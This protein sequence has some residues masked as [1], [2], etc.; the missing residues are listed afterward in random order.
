[1]AYFLCPQESMFVLAKALHTMNCSFSS[2]P[3]SRTFQCP[4]LWLLKT[5]TSLPRRVVL[6][7]YPSVPDLLLSPLIELR[8]PGIPTP[9]ENGPMFLALGYLLETRLQGSCSRSF[10]YCSFSN[11]PKHVQ[12]SFC[13]FEQRLLESKSHAESLPSSSQLHTLWSVLMG[14]VQGLNSMST[15]LPSMSTYQVCFR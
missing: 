12:L 6:E 13:L 2:L 15:D 8:Q 3:S 14:P 9:F 11:A 7:K 4:S 5:L 1:M 10:L